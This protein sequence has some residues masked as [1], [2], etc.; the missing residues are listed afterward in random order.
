MKSLGRIALGAAG[1]MAAALLVA[2]PAS[3]QGWI[4]PDQGRLLNDRFANQ[5]ERLE[6]D[7]ADQAPDGRKLEFSA[8]EKKAIAALRKALDKKDPEKVAAALAAAKAAAVSADAKYA[9]AVLQM[10]HATAVNDPKLQAEAIDTLIASGEFKDPAMLASLYNNQAAY[11]LASNDQFK[12]EIAYAKMVELTP[13]DADAMITLAQMK[14]K[15]GKPTEALALIERAIAVKK[16]ANEEVPTSWAQAAETMS[17]AL[18][19]SNQ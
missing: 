15:S 5:F 13:T 4:P 19:R 6:R 1:T 3:A 8:E 2:F 18:G 11:A 14:N 9:V 7:I 16:A 10:R 17:K 12:A